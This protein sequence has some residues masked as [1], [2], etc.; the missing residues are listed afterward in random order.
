M[1]GRD[2]GVGS[3]VA[4]V[5][6]GPHRRRSGGRVR[7]AGAGRSMRIKHRP[8]LCGRRPGAG[9]TQRVVWSRYFAPAATCRVLA[10][11]A[12]CQDVTATESWRVQTPSVHA[13]LGTPH[14]AVSTLAGP[15]PHTSYKYYD[16]PTLNLEHSCPRGFKRLCGGVIHGQR[17]KASWE[18]I[19]Q[20]QPFFQ[21]ALSCHTCSDQRRDM[22]LPISIM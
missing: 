12:G 3:K 21:C 20:S 2:Q 1:P 8:H 10:P 13:L 7:S 9:T 18:Q 4:G 5:E 16:L 6:G 19:T 11:P 14:Y 17:K 15:S 22:K